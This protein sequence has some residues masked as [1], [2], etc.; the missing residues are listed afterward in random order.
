MRL[1]N[2]WLNIGSFVLGLLAWIIPI[3]SMIQ[4]KKMGRNHSISIFLSMT[5]CAIALWFQIA[6]NNYLV[7][8]QDWGS[9]LDTTSTLNWVAAVLLI[10]TI[11]LNMI[12]LIIYRNTVSD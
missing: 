6:Y 8:L 10:V 4:R 11:F 3:Y 7:N 12:S 9:L 1:N 5:A 2:G